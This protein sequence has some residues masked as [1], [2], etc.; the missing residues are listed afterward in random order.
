MKLIF[1]AIIILSMTVVISLCSFNQMDRTDPNNPAPLDTSKKK[2]TDSDPRKQADCQ[3]LGSGGS[4]A[5]D[6]DC[7][8]ICDD[9]FNGKRDRDDCEEL[10]I[11]L[12]EDFEILIEDLEDGET[13]IDLNTLECLIDIDEEPIADAVR[14]MSQSEAVDFLIEIVENSDLSDILEAED[15]GMVLENLLSRSGNKTLKSILGETDE[16]ENFLYLIGLENNE[17]AFNYLENYVRSECDGKSKTDESCPGGEEI[18]AYCI[19]FLE[20]D[21]DNVEDFLD[22][23]DVFADEYEDAVDDADYAY[24][25][26]FDEDDHRGDFLDFCRWQVIQAKRGN[27]AANPL[28][29]AKPPIN[30]SCPSSGSSLLSKYLIGKFTFA[31]SGTSLY[32]KNP[33]TGR[34]VN[35]RVNKNQEIISAI[36]FISNHCGN[37]SPATGVAVSSYT[38]IH[39]VLYLKKEGSAGNPFRMDLEGNEDYCFTT[40]S[41][42]IRGTWLVYLAYEAGG[43]C[44]FL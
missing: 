38:R 3:S 6:E 39:N 14:K 16:D 22:E 42:S 34:D 24:D 11:G 2:T 9:I 13:D 12:V 30:N 29:P 20:W 26:D 41:S 18:T 32:Y 35:G 17:S 15:E 1:H 10:S 31:N 36:D 7:E 40:T 27:L 8:D 5:G 19:G 25:V 33:V 28:N 4:C 44:E 43:K 23:A 37:G 21:E